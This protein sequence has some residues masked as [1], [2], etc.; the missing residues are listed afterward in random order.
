M[1]AAAKMKWSRMLKTC[2][3]FKPIIVVSSLCHFGYGY[4]AL[5]SL[6][7]FVAVQTSPRL[8]AICHLLFAISYSP[9]PGRCGVFRFAVPCGKSITVSW[10]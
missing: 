8:P 4:G 9:V 6:R 3:E 1:I 5:R 10:L 7:Y 2:R